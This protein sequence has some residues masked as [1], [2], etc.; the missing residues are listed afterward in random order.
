MNAFAPIDAKRLVNAA[1]RTDFPAFI[2]KAFRT[3]KPGE[4]YLPNWHVEAIAAQL[5]RVRTGEVK[6]L[7]INQPPRSLK[8]ITTSVAYPAW[9]LGLDPTKSIIVVSYSNDFAQ[10]LHSQ[11]RSVV[12][13]DRYRELFPETVWE[14]DTGAE[15]VTTLG[16]GRL[17]TSIGGTLTGRGADIIIVDD[18]LKADE[19]MSEAARRK[20]IDFFTGTLL[21]RLDDKEKGA[22]VVVMQ[23]LHEDDL[24]GH[25]ITQGGWQHLNLPA[26]ALRDEPILIGHGRTH[27]R[28]TGDLLHPER[29][30]RP[31]LDELKA[32]MGSPKFSAQYQ[33]EPTPAEG[34]LVKRVWLRTYD[35]IPDVGG[36][37]LSWDIAGTTGN[38]N[39]Y[40][41]CTI[42]KVHKGNHYL[43]D[44]WRGRLEYP[45]LRKMVAVLAQRYRP[46][47]VLIE[48]AGLGLN[49]V[50]DLQRDTPPGM[51]RPIGIKPERSK[52]D[53]MMAQ[54]AKFESGSVYLPKEAAWL[55]D[56]QTELLGFPHT[57]HDDQVDSVAQFLSWHSSRSPFADIPP[58]GPIVI[59]GDDY[60]GS[61]G[62]ATGTACWW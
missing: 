15:A 17:A 10:T 39:D 22:I 28:R 47:T 57:R 27:L 38:T 35:Q 1:L 26:I 58:T 2:E 52:L 41:V 23:R 44:V 20:V 16:G 19:A 25:L 6:R 13:S 56:F 34:N 32:A 11:F 14:K 24:A 29:E 45:D 36:Y 62:G 3:V 9:L 33:Q 42:W 46:A 37:F 8:S 48:E 54:S 12:D 60:L 61:Y 31:V 53:R 5:D 55:A 7:L 43:V 30:S 49:L 4:P 18:P 21:S 40:S 51:Q 50:Q 59:R